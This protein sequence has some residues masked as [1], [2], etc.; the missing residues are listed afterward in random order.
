MQDEFAASFDAADIIVIA[1]PYNQSNIPVEERLNPHTLVRKIHARGKEAFLFGEAPSNT[2]SWTA[3]DSANAIVRSVLAQAIPHD[4]IAILSNGGFGGIH[5]K[6]I[7][8]IPNT[9]KK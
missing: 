1:P 7:N 4:V 2:E 8:E 5:K 3:T 6:F 9:I